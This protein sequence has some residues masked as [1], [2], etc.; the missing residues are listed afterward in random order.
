MFLNILPD[1][2]FKID[3][4]GL[5]N[6]SG[7]AGPGFLSETVRLVRPIERDRARNG[8]MVR[9]TRKH[10]KWEITLNYN[11][12]TLAEFDPVYN[13]LMQKRGTK[14]AFYVSLPQYKVPKDSTFATYAQGNSIPITSSSNVAGN[15]ILEIDEP[16]GSIKVGDVFN[17]VDSTD[18]THKQAYMVARVETS[19]LNETPPTAGSVRIHFFPGLQKDTPSGALVEFDGPLF[20]VKQK[21]DIQEYVLNNENLY[22][23]TVNLE[24]ALS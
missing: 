12:L 2:N 13:F 16:S 21:Q 11:P 6:A 24:E 8:F 22:S 15:R 20:K 3:T 4:A 19:A 5:E 10:S 18:T 7:V 1:P 23:F 14:K 9:K 17:V